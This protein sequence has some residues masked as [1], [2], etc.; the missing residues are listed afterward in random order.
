MSI[1]IAWVDENVLILSE[2][3]EAGRIFQKMFEFYAE[4]IIASIIGVVRDIA[5]CSMNMSAAARFPVR[6]KQAPLRC[7]LGRRTII[8]RSLSL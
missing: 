6:L 4:S 8:A 1:E 5:P 2:L 7:R 3:P